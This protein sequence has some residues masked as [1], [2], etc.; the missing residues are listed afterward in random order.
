MNRTM[1]SSTRYSH[2]GSLR[3]GYIGGKC[4]HCAF[5]ANRIV[6]V[7]SGHRSTDVDAIR[8]FEV[9]YRRS[10]LFDHTSCVLTWC[11]RQL[12]NEFLVSLVRTVGSQSHVRIRRIHTLCGVCVC[13]CLCVRDREREHNIWFVCVN[14]DFMRQIC[15]C[16]R[17]RLCVFVC[18]WYLCVCV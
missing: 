5:V 4:V 6:R 17:E 15:V 1:C 13:V 18:V 8:F 9:L 3:K 10:H 11:V 7:R 16:E 14:E 2:T 12:R